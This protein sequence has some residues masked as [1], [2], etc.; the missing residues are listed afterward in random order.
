[1]NATPTSKPDQLRRV[2]PVATSAITLQHASLRNS[3]DASHFNLKK[4]CMQRAGKCK[5]GR[6]HRT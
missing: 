3:R 5:S 4:Q 6:K 1:M 2:I